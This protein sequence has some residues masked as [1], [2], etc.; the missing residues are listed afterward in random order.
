MG[1]QDMSDLA[2]LFAESRQEIARSRRLLHESA[3]LVEIG[4]R[5]VTESR[6][7]LRQ[8]R[9]P[10]AVACEKASDAKSDRLLLDRVA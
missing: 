9:G 7:L 6:L 1:Q 2:L 8:A 3:E 5:L 4:R 10:R